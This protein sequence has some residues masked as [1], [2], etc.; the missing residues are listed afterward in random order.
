LSRRER[1]V[2]ALVATGLSD[3]QIAQDLLLS[4]RTVSKHLQSVYTKLH[5][6][7]RSAATRIALEQ[8]LV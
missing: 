4:P 8:G 5:V 6:N 1:E 7:S 3:G 2:L